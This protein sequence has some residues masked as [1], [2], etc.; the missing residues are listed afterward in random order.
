MPGTAS[1]A[2]ASGSAGRDRRIR[3]E[4]L[5]KVPAEPAVTA[6]ESNSSIVSGYVAFR[7]G[8]AVRGAEAQDATSV[9]AHAAR[10]ATAMCFI[11]SPPRK[12]EVVWMQYIPYGTSWKRRWM[13][14]SFMD[15]TIS[16]AMSLGET[17]YFA[18]W[19]ALHRLCR[20][21]KGA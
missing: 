8:G 19:S 17:Q 18:A 4:A 16:V 15:S 3:E 12:T 11:G 13:V 10:K 21:R 9:A 1:D 5:A 6:R 7:D 14:R 2:S 20:G